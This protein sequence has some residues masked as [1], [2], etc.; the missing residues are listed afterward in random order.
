MS[1]GIK[2]RH[3]RVVAGSVPPN[4]ASIGWGVN[5]AVRFSVAFV[6][7]ASGALVFRLTTTAARPPLPLV[8]G[9]TTLVAAVLWLLR[10]QLDRVANVLRFGRDAGGYESVRSLLQRMSTTLPIDEVVPQ[11]AES[12]GRSAH[13]SRAEVRIALD[14][15]EQRSQV[16][17]P[18]APAGQMPLTVQIRHLGHQIGELEVETQGPIDDHDRRLLSDI[19]GPAGLAMST[20][21]L[22]WSLRARIEALEVI[23]AQL[24]RSQERLI[25]AR[26]AAREQLRAEIEDRVLPHLR[27]VTGAVADMG[28]AMDDGRPPDGAETAAERL[29]AGLDALRSIARGIFPPRLGEA[30]LE[31]CLHGF[32]ESIEVPTAVRVGGDT[33]VLA[34][35]SDIET[36]VYFCLVTAM[37]AAVSAGATGMSVEVIVESHLV[38]CSL[39][40]DHVPTLRQTVLTPIADRV[41]AF[42]G[43]FEIVGTDCGFA[44]VAGIPL[45]S[46]PDDGPVTVESATMPPRRPAGAL[47]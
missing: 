38:T 47:R 1:N 30:D 42:G 27:E 25:G 2:S 34:A 6:M 31:V 33:S 19:S 17:P 35:L 44:L 46:A 13:S 26:L 22:T 45:Q 36:C 3:V 39:S 32:V 43:Q 7:F 23:N 10:H 41:E 29:S 9:W 24:R 8:A 14:D 28:E 18:A 12:L 5:A 4:Q 20:V 21:R 11:L 40:V 16:W 15:G 37:P